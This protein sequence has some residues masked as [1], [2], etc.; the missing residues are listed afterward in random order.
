MNK[1]RISENIK[2]LREKS[3]LG[4]TDIANNLGVARTTISHYESGHSEPSIEKMMLL[5]EMFQVSISD[6]IEKDLS[7]SLDT[8]TYVNNNNASGDITRLD[9][10]KKDSLS[11][12]EIK[13][14]KD[15]RTPFY[16]VLVS[17]GEHGIMEW[18]RE[19]PTG[20]I[21]DIPAFKA[22]DAAFPV[23]GFS[24]EPEISNGDIVGVREM[25]KWDFVDTAGV[26]MLITD[27]ERMIKRLKPDDDDDN[28]LWCLSNNYAPFKLLRTDIRKMFK[29]VARICVL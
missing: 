4:Q 23:L 28:M 24:M 18:G 22:A 11:K 12:G 21:I 26:Y 29:V 5:S 8:L 9:K 3:S 7:E 16:N 6:L 27:H 20:Y 2:Y 1:V 19:E 14:I 13:S 15:N 10:R 25:Q 17:A